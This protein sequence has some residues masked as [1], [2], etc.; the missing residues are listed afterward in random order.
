ML[1]DAQWYCLWESVKN[2]ALQQAKKYK[3]PEMFE[4]FMDHC[5]LN[6]LE[7]LK[8]APKG[9]ERQY[10]LNAIM[11]TH[12]TITR[13]IAKQSKISY[14]AKLEDSPIKQKQEVSEFLQD[15]IDNLTEEEA[16]IADILSQGVSLRKLYAEQRT[17]TD[18]KRVAAIVKSLKHKLG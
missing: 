17:S 4:M 18:K 16:E 14:R 12:N 9:K 2:Y 8:K 1:T 3:H 6:I 13:H 15:S 10:A 7:Q 5:R 11:Y